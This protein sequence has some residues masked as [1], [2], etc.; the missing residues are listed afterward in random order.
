METI[1]ITINL[2]ATDLS[3]EALEKAAVNHVVSMILE[4]KIV[5]RYDEYGDG[6]H[7]EEMEGDAIKGLRGRA[8]EIVEDKVKAVVEAEVP[9]VV[10]E[11]LDGEFH[12]VTRYGD[13]KGPT[14]LRTLIAETAEKWLEASVDA[15][16]GESP[17]YNRPKSRRLE[18]LIRSEV[19]RLYKETIAAETKKI[20]AEI[21]KQMSGK[22]NAAIADVVNR[23]VGAK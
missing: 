1:P 12:P 11:V 15:R 10:Q 4:S 6:Y 8:T 3:K 5:R 14:T 17:S 13:K 7:Y 22:I 19:D 20:G 2:P 16:S 21:K 23:I 9:K 18:Y